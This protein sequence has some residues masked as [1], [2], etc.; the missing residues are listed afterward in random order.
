MAGL[1]ETSPTYQISTDCD[2]EFAESATK[3]ASE[4]I[5]DPAI[6]QYI[7]AVMSS[8]NKAPIQKM[9]ET[10]V[11]LLEKGTI[12]PRVMHQ[13]RESYESIQKKKE[14]VLSKKMSQLPPELYSVSLHF[15]SLF[16][17][18]N[19]FQTAQKIKTIST[20]GGLSG[21]ERVQQIEMALGGEY[22]T[23]CQWRGNTC[24]VSISNLVTCR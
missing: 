19:L 9:A 11:F 16:F 14:G 7:H 1:F 12:T 22:R 17:F 3:L 2:V 5:T 23:S 21:N 13:I 10:S 15:S 4:H 8:C 24:S 20:S 6:V 18:I